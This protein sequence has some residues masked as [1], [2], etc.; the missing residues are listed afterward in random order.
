MRSARTWHDARAVTRRAACVHA[1]AL[2]AGCLDGYGGPPVEP[3]HPAKTGTLQVTV[4]TTGA[5]LDPNGYVLTVDDQLERARPTANA[6]VS[7]GRLPVGRHLVVLRDVA[8]MYV[9]DMCPPT[10]RRCRRWPCLAA[11]ELDRSG[12]PSPEAP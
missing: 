9:S 3:H 6:T 2:A 11:R 8:P 10:M 12:N 1:L 7:I 4:S 5:D